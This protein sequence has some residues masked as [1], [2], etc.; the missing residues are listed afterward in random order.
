MGEKKTNFRNKSHYPAVVITGT[1]SGGP[2]FCSSP[3]VLR[4]AA[5]RRWASELLAGDECTS[6]YTAT[7]SSDVGVPTQ[8]PARTA[9]DTW[10]AV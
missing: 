1:D 8:R 5:R 7:S 2:V 10:K 9:Q 6:Q 3:S 4:A